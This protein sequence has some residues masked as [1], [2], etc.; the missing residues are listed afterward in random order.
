M[1]EVNVYIPNFIWEIHNKDLEFLCL[2]IEKGLYSVS[3]DRLN[4]LV[5]SINVNFSKDILIELKKCESSFY[6]SF[7]YELGKMAEKYEEDK[8]EK[9]IVILAIF[10]YLMGEV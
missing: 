7:S 2:S 6:K 8:F 4:N 3:L 1:D 10:G 5:E 9:I